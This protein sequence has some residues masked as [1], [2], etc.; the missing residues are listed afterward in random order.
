MYFASWQPASLSREAH[1]VGCC[2]HGACAAAGAHCT[3][4][5]QRLMTITG[6]DPFAAVPPSCRSSLASNSKRFLTC[7]KMLCAQVIS[8]CNGKECTH[9]KSCGSKMAG[10]AAACAGGG[11][12]GGEGGLPHLALWI[13]GQE[14]LEPAVE[15]EA[16]HHIRA[17][18]AP[19]PVRSLQ[20]QEGHP[21]NP[22]D[23]PR[24]IRAPGPANAFRGDPTRPTS[25]H[26]ICALLTSSQVDQL[27][28]VGSRSDTPA[29]C[30]LLF[31]STASH[32][33]RRRREE[34]M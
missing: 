26:V 32:S 9:H 29:G 12:G 22:R 10:E 19:H 11:G 6:T 34:T 33:S 5:P 28:T 7:R 24:L 4:T 14:D 27:G 31:A 18:P 30:I 15:L 2:R 23:A 16:L 21:C 1:R 13:A 25:V 17:H 20:Q 8:Q 3:W